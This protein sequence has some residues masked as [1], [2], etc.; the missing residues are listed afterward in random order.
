MDKRYVEM[1]IESGYL[2]GEEL[3]AEAVETSGRL[4]P[5]TLCI[6]EVN[7]AIV[8]GDPPKA[9]LK[10]TTDRLSNIKVKSGLFKKTLAFT[11]DGTDYK[12]EIKG[13]KKVLEFFGLLA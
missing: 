11:L 7:V 4:E 6:S 2:D 5:G 8:T 13:A 9:I 10:T 1:L 3:A 12:F